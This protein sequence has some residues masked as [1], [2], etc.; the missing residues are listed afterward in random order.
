MVIIGLTVMTINFLKE[1]GSL[2]IDSSMYDFSPLPV[3]YGGNVNSTVASNV[4]KSFVSD[5]YKFEYFS[6]SN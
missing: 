4:M 5:E 1:S 3:T 2:V 6:G